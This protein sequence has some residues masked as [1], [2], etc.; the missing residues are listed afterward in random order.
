MEYKT[1]KEL[2]KRHQKHEIIE[3]MRKNQ[4]TP[5]SPATLK[6]YKSVILSSFAGRKYPS[7]P[8][9]DNI[10]PHVVDPYSTLYLYLDEVLFD[11]D[12]V[13]AFEK[14]NPARTSKRLSSQH[15]ESARTIAA[16]LWSKDCKLT[17]ED[18]ISGNAVNSA[19]QG[20]VYGERTLRNWVKDLCPDRKPGRRRK[21]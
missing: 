15:R 11:A 17:I 18:V 7:N 13:E 2:L 8:L 19:F 20:H 10:L 6:P 14:A 5:Y 3:M 16:N 1:G 9:S 21:T 4:L 12:D